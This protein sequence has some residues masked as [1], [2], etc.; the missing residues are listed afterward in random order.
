MV[1]YFGK[2]STL[3]DG[4]SLFGISRCGGFEPAINMGCVQQRA[5]NTWCKKSIHQSLVSGAAQV[6][7]DVQ[8][9][10]VTS[11]PSP[12]PPPLSY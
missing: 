10:P 8:N 5:V 11:S 6:S 2:S 3:C 1:L 9:T 7:N 4:T 12:P